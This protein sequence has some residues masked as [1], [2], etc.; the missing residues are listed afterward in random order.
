MNNQSVF[1]LGYNA[2]HLPVGFRIINDGSFL[3]GEMPLEISYSCVAIP[4]IGNYKDECS[5]DHVKQLSGTTTL[6]GYFYYTPG[7]L[8]L[9]VQY[10]QSD[11]NSESNVHQFQYDRYNKLIGYQIVNGIYAFTRHSYGY[12]G[13][14]ITLDTLYS[15]LGE[16]FLQVSTLHYD[17]E[18]RIIKEDIEVLERNF[19]PV[20]ELST[21]EYAY[22]SRGNLVSPLATSYDNK[23]SYLRTE[24]LWMFIHRNYS[25]NN[26]QGVTQYNNKDLP[27]GFS[28]N[29]FGFLGFEE[30]FEI[31]YICSERTRPGRK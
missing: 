25:L 1:V 18:G 2:Y 21:K 29:V 11:F 24:P 15:D 14:R 20:S 7:G 28:D 16:Q 17:S 12:S 4:G 31:E 30:P 13:N 22:D 23:V 27:L 10:I 9:S 5:I 8:P 3:K 6:D 19:A 26:P